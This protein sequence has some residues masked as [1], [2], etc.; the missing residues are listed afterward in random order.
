LP[1]AADQ[2]RLF[3][4]ERGGEIVARVAVSSQTCHRGR[5]IIES[6]VVGRIARM[7]RELMRHRSNRR[8]APAAAR[9]ALMTAWS[10]KTRRHERIDRFAQGFSCRSVAVGVRRDA[11]GASRHA[12]CQ[13]PPKVRNPCHRRAVAGMTIGSDWYQ[14]F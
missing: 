8:A 1:A 5:Q 12:S 2:W 6:A 10:E 14:V 3:M 13:P 7:R 4:L 11:F 9:S